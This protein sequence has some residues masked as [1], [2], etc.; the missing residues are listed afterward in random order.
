[1]R[2]KLKYEPIPENASELASLIV[3]SVMKV[4]NIALDFSEKSIEYVER[5]ID[6]FRR[7]NVPVHQIGET[8]FCLGCY[9]G[10]ILAKND[11]GAWVSTASTDM[12]QFADAPII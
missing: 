6:S 4:D 2:L 5:I 10:E 8:L 11:G 7:E 12:H 3:A 1:M 9:L